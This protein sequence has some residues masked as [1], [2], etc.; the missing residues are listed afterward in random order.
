ML[1][2]GNLKV[3]EVKDMLRMPQK[4]QVVRLIVITVEDVDIQVQS[5][6]YQLNLS[7]LLNGLTSEEEKV[8]R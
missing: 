1:G 4:A 2:F 6:L 7:L 8:Y 5:S 3:L